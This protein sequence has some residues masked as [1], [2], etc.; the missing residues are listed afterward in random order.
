MPQ[1]FNAI[2]KATGER[3]QVYLDVSGKYYI[4]PK[5]SSWN[6]LPEELEIVGEA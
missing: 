5:Y 1:L 4:S 2:L 6:F 3:L